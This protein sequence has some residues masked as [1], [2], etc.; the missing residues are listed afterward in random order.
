MLNRLKRFLALTLSMVMFISMMPMDVLAETV[1]ATWDLSSTAA[2][3][4]SDYTLTEDNATVTASGT[5]FLEVGSSVT[6]TFQYQNGS[7]DASYSSS[8]SD[9]ASVGST[10]RTG[11]KT[12]TYTTTL[13]AKAVGTATIS[14]KYYN[15]YTTLTVYVVAASPRIVISGDSKLDISQSGAS[16]TLSLA[17]ANL[18]ENVAIS[19]V[20]W[21]VSGNATLS[22]KSTTGVVVTPTSAAAVGNT[23]TVT[24]VATLNDADATELT[25][26][27][28]ITYTSIET[29]IV[30]SSTQYAW[31]NEAKT[32]TGTSN[33][34]NNHWTVSNNS[35]MKLDSWTG[36]TTTSTYYSTG[37][38]YDVSLQVSELG[39]YT[40]GHS[41]ST[42]Q[43]GTDNNTKSQNIVVVVYGVKLNSLSDMYV[44]EEQTVTYTSKLP[45][46][47]TLS[48]SEADKSGSDVV[49][50]DATT[51]VIT[52]KN[53]GTATITL[54]VTESSGTKHTYTTE[55]EVIAA[56]NVAVSKDAVTLAVGDSTELTVTGATAS[57]TFY[58]SDETIASCSYSDGKLTITGVKDGDAVVYGVTTSGDTVLVDV[59]VETVGINVEPGNL[60]T[61]GGNIYYVYPEIVVPAGATYT[62]AVS[63]DVTDGDLITGGNYNT[64]DGSLA[65]NTSEVSANTDVVVTFTMAV[66]VNGVTTNYTDTISVKL[67]PK[68]ESATT[69][70]N[71][72]F[73]DY[74]GN[75]LSTQTVASADAIVIPGQPNSIDGYTYAGF[76][77]VSTADT[78]SY[79]TGDTIDDADLTANTILFAQYNLNQYNV[80]FTTAYGTAPETQTVSHGGLVTEP[81]DLGTSG[82]YEFSHWYL[83]TDS[84][85]TAY[86]FYTPVTGDI[87]L[88][89]K[90]EPKTVTVTLITYLG[91]YE[92]YTYNYVDNKW[93]DSSN[94]VVSS[95]TLPKFTSSDTDGNGNS[96]YQYTITNT[97]SG[98]T[99]P[100]TFQFW[101]LADDT[102]YVKK[103]GNTS[104][105]LTSIVSAGEDVTYNAIYE[106][107]SQS[108]TESN[109]SHANTV[110]VTVQLVDEDGNVQ[111]TTVLTDIQVTPAYN[112]TTLMSG[113]T[114][115]GV[116]SSTAK[117]GTISVS[118]L[119][120]KTVTINNKTYTVTDTSDVSVSDLNVV[121]LCSQA[122]HVYGGTCRGG[123]W[124]ALGVITL[125]VRENLSSDSAP[126]LRVNYYQVP[127]TDYNPSDAVL[128][129]TK[130]PTIAAGNVLVHSLYENGVV[131]STLTCIDHE[132]ENGV[133]DGTLAQNGNY[134][135]LNLYY[136][137]QPYT[138]TYHYLIEGTT[139]ELY[140]SVTV[141]NLLNGYS[142]SQVSPSHDRAD[143]T[144]IDETDYTL[145]NPSQ[146]VVNVTIDGANAVVYVYYKLNVGNLTITKIV[147]NPDFT[148][149]SFTFTVDDGDPSTTD[150]TATIS[151][152]TK[153]DDG[154]FTGTATVTD[155]QVG[156]YTVKETAVSGYT[157]DKTDASVTIA[158]GQTA[159]VTFTNTR[160]ATLIIKKAKGANVT[161]DATFGFTVATEDGKLINPTAG[162]ANIGFDGSET[163]TVKGDS[164]Y[165][166]TEAITDGYYLT[167]VA[168]T[169]NG[170]E[171]ENVS[172]NNT[173]T[174]T[175]PAGAVVEITYT[176]DEQLGEFTVNK[177]GSGALPLDGVAFTLY[178]AEENDS[179]ATAIA[180]NDVFT[181]VTTAQDNTE[182]EAN[183]DGT[184]VF[185]NLPIGTYYVVETQ[186]AAG[187]QEPNAETHSAKI[188]VIGNN[189]NTGV[190]TVKINGSEINATT[191]TNALINT[192]SF[193]LKK[194]VVDGLYDKTTGKFNFT[195]ELKNTNADRLNYAVKVN[196]VDQTA[197]TDGTYN[198][199]AS[200]ANGEYVTIEGMP[201]DTVITVTETGADADAWDIAWSNDDE[202]TGYEATDVVITAN[203]P[204]QTL[205]ATNTRVTKKLTATKTWS[206]QD[207]HFELR[208]TTIE[209]KLYRYTTSVADAEVVDTVNMTVESGNS[210]TIKVWENL[211]AYNAAGTAYNYYIVEAAIAN[212][213]ASNNDTANT[214]S[215]TDGDESI[216]ITNTLNVNQMTVTKTWVETA[217]M[218]NGVAADIVSAR[219]GMTF[220]L[221]NTDW[222]Q[223]NE[224]VDMAGD[225][226]DYSVVF[227][228]S[229]PVSKAYVLVESMN[230][231]GGY[232]YDN[233]AITPVTDANG[234][235]TGFTVV[236]TLK[237]MDVTVTKKW[238]DNGITGL[239]HPDATF[240][241]YYTNTEGKDIV[242]KTISTPTESDEMDNDV[243]T[244]LFDGVPLRTDYKVRET[245][246]AEETIYFTVD[247]TG[248]AVVDGAATITNES[249][250]GALVIE[251]AID[252]CGTD[253][254]TTLDN[255]IF[256]FEYSTDGGETWEPAGSI[257]VDLDGGETNNTTDE[258]LFPV[259]TEVMVREVL[260]EEQQIEWELDTTASNEE[261]T[262]VID[263]TETDAAAYFENDRETIEYLNVIKTWNDKNGDPNRRPESVTFGLYYSD[264][265]TPVKKDGENWTVTL[266][267][268]PSETQQTVSF[269]NVPYNANGYVVIETMPES[270]GAYVAVDAS[271]ELSYSETTAEFTN[272]PTEAVVTVKKQIVD[273]T[274]DFVNGMESEFD[275]TVTT[276]ADENYNV[277]G[278]DI[279][280]EDSFEFEVKIGTEYTLTENIDAD[281]WTASYENATK[282]TDNTA[283][284][285]ADEAAE[286]IVVTNTRNSVALELDK[287][288]IDDNNAQGTRP[289]TIDVIVEVL[290][291]NT[292]TTVTYDGENVCETGISAADL[293]G[294]DFTDYNGMTLPKTDLDGVAN[295]Y[296]LNEVLNTDGVIEG[297]NEATYTS[298]VTGVV[299]TVTAITNQLGNGSTSISFT[300]NWVD[301]SNELSVRPSTTDYAGWLHLYQSTDEENWTEVSYTA[302]VTGSGNAYS[303][304]YS[305]LP[306][307]DNAGKLYYYAVAETIPTGSEYTQSG[308]TIEVADGTLAVGNDDTLTNKLVGSTELTITKLW[309]D[310]DGN[311]LETIPE[312]TLNTALTRYVTVNGE[313]TTATAFADGYIPLTADNKWT[314][315]I[316]VDKYDADG[317]LYT[318]GVVEYNNAADYNADKQTAGLDNSIEEGSIVE[319][320]DDKKYAVDY[321]AQDN[322]QIIKN[323]RQSE[324]D[325]IPGTKTATEI[326]LNTYVDGEK[327]DV[328]DS[329]TY[330]ITWN[331]TT[332]K[333]Q[334][335]TI[336]DE[337]KP[338]L[339][340][341]AHTASSDDTVTAVTGA[342][343][344]LDGEH[345]ETTNTVTWQF[346]AKPFHS[347]SVTVT[348]QL[349]DKI[350]ALY[351]ADKNLV[352]ENE[353]TVEI[354]SD[355]EL[356]STPVAEDIPVSHPAIDVEKEITTTNE[357]GSVKTAGYEL[358]ETV[359]YKVTVTNTGNL[360]LTD[361]KVVDIRDDATVLDTTIKTMAL[362][363]VEYFTYTHTVTEEDL[364]RGTIYNT[365]TV[366]A[367][368]PTT[369][370]G[371]LT[372]SDNE[373]VTT[374]AVEPQLT[375]VKDVIT[376][377]EN[378]S[379]K[380]GGY[381]LGETVSYKVTLT[382][383]GNVT[384][385]NVIFTDDRVLDYTKVTVDGAT[386][387]NVTENDKITS[388]NVGDMAPGKVITFTYDYVIVEADLWNVEVKNVA[389]ATGIYD[390]PDPD[391]TVTA[392]D[393]E[394]VTTVG[395]KAAIDVTKAV[396]DEQDYYTED[397]TVDFTITVTN[398]G[399]VTLSNV[400]L[401]DVMNNSQPVVIESTADYTVD[402]AKNGTVTVAMA[403][404]MLPGASITL[405]A[406][407]EVL[408]YDLQLDTITN[409]VTAVGKTEKGNEVKDDAEADFRTDKLITYTVNKV[410][411]NTVNDVQ[412]TSVT[413]ELK[414]NGATYKTATLDK[415]NG[416]KYTFT[417]LP[418]TDTDHE[419][420]DYIAV[421]TKIGNS[422]VENNAANGYNVT[423]SEETGVNAESESIT[424]TNTQQTTSVVV[425]KYW[426]DGEWTEGADP[427]DHLLAFATDVP[428]ALDMDL[429]NDQTVESGKKDE[430]AATIDKSIN[431]NGTIW[432]YT[433]TKLP[434]YDA[435]GDKITYSA[436]EGTVEGF[437]AK[438]ETT[439]TVVDGKAT[440]I[441]A[442][443]DEKPEKPVKDLVEDQTDLINVTLGD[444]NMA[445]DGGTITYTIAWSNNYATTRE[446][447][448]IDTL[449]TGLEYI[450][451]KNTVNTET[452]EN[453]QTITWIFEAK[454]FEDGVITV[455]VDVDRA[456]IIAAATAE[457]KY[458]PTVTNT[459][460]MIVSDDDVKRDS[461]PVETSVYNPI[462][463][464]VKEVTDESHN[465]NG[466][467]LGEEISYK[468]TITNDGNVPLLNVNVEDT[469]VA[470]SNMEFTST[471]DEATFVNGVISR[472]EIGDVVTLTY[473]YTVTEADVKAEAHTVVNEVTATGTAE[474]AEQ[475]DVTDNDSTTSKT[476]AATGSWIPE[477]GE[478]GAVGKTIVG[479]DLVA[480]EFKFAITDETHNKTI[481]GTN[482]ANG[483]VTFDGEFTYTLTDLV[484]FEDL[485]AADD[486]TNAVYTNTFT[487][488]VKEITGE[489]DTVDYSNDVYTY[490]V[491]Y[492][493]NG[494]GAIV[495]VIDS[496]TM[497]DGKTE[498][499][500]IKVEFDNYAHINA[501]VTKAWENV[502]LVDVPAVEITLYRKA[503]AEMPETV[504]GTWDPIGT[505]TIASGETSVTWEN[506]ERVD[507]YGVEYTYIATETVKGDFAG[508]Y[509]ASAVVVE[510]GDPDA[511]NV[512]T[513][514]FTNSRDLGAANG[515][516]V[517][518]TIV[519][520][521]KAL[522]DEMKVDKFDFVVTVPG[523]MTVGDEITYT[524]GTETY[525]AEI[526]KNDTYGT[527]FVIE[528]IVH[529]Q[530]ATVTNKLPI[531]TYNVVELQDVENAY[532][533]AADWGEAKNQQI[534]EKDKTVAFT[535]TNTVLADGFTI[536][537]LWKQPNGNSAISTAYDLNG[538]EHTATFGLFYDADGENAVQQNGKALVSTTT[539]DGVVVFE[540]V[541]L[542][543][544]SGNNATYYIKEISTTTD[545]YVLNTAAIPVV[546]NGTK[547]VID[548]EKQVVV[549]E[550]QTYDLTIQK[551]IDWNGTDVM[552]IDFTI[553]YSYDE[554]GAVSEALP[555][556]EGETT[557][558]VIGE[559]GASYSAET[560]EITHT[561]DVITVPYGTKV[562]VTETLPEADE[563]GNYVW[564]NEFD[565]LDDGESFITVNDNDDH[566]IVTVTNT[567]AY[568]PELTVEKTYASQ[569]KVLEEG[570]SYELGDTVEYTIKVENT[571]NVT[572]TNVKIT[573]D[574]FDLTGDNVHF[575]A[576][577]EEATFDKE[578]STVSVMKPGDE[579][580]FLY[581]VVITEDIILEEGNVVTNTV[582]VSAD[583]PKDPENPIE[584]EDE[585][586]IPVEEP[587][588]SIDV[589]K[590]GEEHEGAYELGETI[591][592]TIVV[593]NTGNLTISDIVV[594]DELTGDQWTIESLAPEAS[595]TF[596]ASYTVTEADLFAD[597]VINVATATG[598][599]PTD[600]D[601]TDE[602][603]EKDPTDEPNDQY[604][605]V[606]TLTN[607]PERGYFVLGEKA[608]FEIT[609]TNTGN[610]TLYNVIVNEELEGAT[611]VAESIE[612]VTYSEDG[613][614]ATIDQLDPVAFETAG[615]VVVL[616][617]VYTIT[618]DDLGKT[619]DLGGENAVHN[620]NNTLTSES[621]HEDPN[622]PD[623]VP[624][625]PDPIDPVPVPVDDVTTVSV[626]K[627]WNDVENQFGT[628]QTITVN[629]LAD[630][631]IYKTAAIS[632][633]ENGAW[634][635][636]FDKLPVHNADTS[637]IEYTVVEETVAGYDTT[638][639]SVATEDG[640][641]WTITNTLQQY[642]LTVR[643]WY[644]QIGGEVA[645]DTFTRTYYYGESYNVTSPKING[646]SVDIEVVSGVIT[647]NAE[648]DVIYT[649]IDYRLTVYY[650]YEDGTTAA[651]THRN[652]LH[653][654]DGYRVVSPELEGYVA[655]RRLV[656]GTMPGH[657]LVYTVIYVP[658]TV[659]IDEYGVPL[660]IGSIVMNVGDCF[661]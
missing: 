389:T 217:T 631:E 278:T 144:D 291:G 599:A 218:D 171:Q 310:G 335:I 378:G 322:V 270:D 455:T 563:D 353:A 107:S 549:N 457:G 134:Y 640:A 30:T 375:L 462:I 436:T 483:N 115:T 295:E 401:T 302:T 112:N 508:S 450:G 585:E 304:T 615:E 32:I 539:D 494:E 74:Y 404:P 443:D 132:W 333:A 257:T 222:A 441:N 288:W 608:E 213:T 95:I 118:D 502:E 548:V 39:M 358:G 477:T 564:T 138:A 355:P 644:E 282:A 572:L 59:T 471:N 224:T 195:I 386:A 279:G 226:A 425:T 157:A 37:T 400:T 642:T 121:W 174:I 435:E 556:D 308:A 210:Q 501:T 448:I 227:T 89:A 480:G 524:V 172:V 10:N 560:G 75:L 581:E 405:S 511:D 486:E 7:D 241:L 280:H 649:P 393:N 408:L 573:D 103:D 284:F 23:V 54:T 495:A 489:D 492:T 275:F 96:Y 356:K 476:Y 268:D 482:D 130:T 621:T 146:A 163:F 293:D 377:N 326:T 568:N 119:L 64:T 179:L 332:N 484:E 136:Y 106:P 567:R 598:K 472:M 122:A 139:T 442:K 391:E 440:F 452:E 611:F 636:T 379:T 376:K 43:N 63:D 428:S 159:S 305:N 116:N 602:D 512:K 318:Y 158:G 530:T 381:V 566:N 152:F 421:E 240:E 166:I 256:A 340:Y 534:L 382:N 205:T 253:W 188:E 533:Y 183:E 449:P 547:F 364:E 311:T 201:L 11:K 94:N 558:D 13:T 161:H 359:S 475:D 248:V 575:D 527:Y 500:V 199:N 510:L 207:N 343:A 289:E 120:G 633:D 281:D 62:I 361:V 363:A 626:T 461:N 88:V 19:S 25:T 114:T 580:Y 371:N 73:Y 211:P 31:I 196:G 76:D 109:G 652:T 372:D 336:T 588:P 128:L 526:Q 390:T 528:D 635:C 90:W 277:A 233:T 263:A 24:A 77:V 51:G 81:A 519:N 287:T 623:P 654:N 349:N 587:A 285:T 189:S 350:D 135:V 266:T 191:I 320:S 331:N 246:L 140:P 347:G 185:S 416:W 110:N 3:Y 184:A 123:T 60:T 145:V 55:V 612:G 403:E 544:K 79:T 327:V 406:S 262:H 577:N 628:R 167:G 154:T 15:T 467:Q 411:K 271:D 367:D 99:K 529:G 540:N 242:V 229:M 105:D 653:I 21:T 61:V 352:A 265:E 383:S 632:A 535:A 427:A 447:T 542:T 660:N 142:H 36:S 232:H 208:P 607:L 496:I 521:E 151:D 647:G 292:W 92:T 430:T 162:N 261:L 345:D 487:Y 20:E 309:L 478:N 170:T 423:Y 204:A 366:T 267:T 346:I 5:I 341:D 552:D 339:T 180:K 518:K 594:T 491:T 273:N 342:E 584:D 12:K 659:I 338:Y 177:T 592:Y 168:I 314:T 223:L 131:S 357:D 98:K 57:V 506:L 87:N 178:K 597:E 17:S 546:S 296:R 175:I 354:G 532:D 413:V 650:V 603:D 523:D 432:T 493:D 72:T 209:Y 609:V 373:T 9:C 570:D 290:N 392:T 78:E 1:S 108:G 460:Q 71:V 251:K 362:G 541:A 247:S 619:E 470:A 234:N 337:L 344:L 655:S 300:K 237:T 235:V 274:L 507:E 458:D 445:V 559:V 52:A 117:F 148:T 422:E 33:T 641:A 133:V 334:V 426:V 437:T 639:E 312:T 303:V 514:G 83:S 473:T 324:D 414:R 297:Q 66:T 143:T 129:A 84:T 254:D 198:I 498:D 319:F 412:P 258:I 49:D 104:L 446:I 348:V 538:D 276:D 6:L 56:A 238:D 53:A 46:G 576:I 591:N 101:V 16:A 374:E 192:T 351:K 164:T 249:N 97:T 583:D 617:A 299:G 444:E 245:A 160:N 638:Y 439:L 298:T 634:T 4:A 402:T 605:V 215:L 203:E 431:A 124:N 419:N 451:S 409:K 586:D 41:W 565:G 557:A 126:K 80:T 497:N 321:V 474:S 394:T 85:Q 613:T 610:L 301:N 329:W 562:T 102:Q 488:T 656:S 522:T 424:I 86:N 111:G 551:V 325:P 221:T 648:Y 384:L 173:Q 150:K 657:D 18:S 651:P 399:N 596:E 545:N 239:E 465:E 197:T 323:T 380:M 579:I 255:P 433:F 536:N 582:T 125:T 286:E 516:S 190:A 517:T 606:K 26:N 113:Y 550:L 216:N 368:D 28:T 645:A 420:F 45:T 306:R 543:D 93:Y 243:D 194:T 58:S 464:V 48:W 574:R 69:Y 68:D 618:E 330:T 187:Y 395:V 589:V 604:T 294:Y 231:G 561:G 182:T 590:T 661:E 65:L 622:D 147:K 27:Y 466:Y 67:T 360:T 627:V 429:T 537:K 181:I 525:T 230:G 630:G 236:N 44:G 228:R 313:K 8:N 620:L 417:D 365:V 629:L 454:P 252:M 499:T 469:I 272:Y 438:T 625:E 410:W 193:T 600:E 316:T 315:K 614:S 397:E 155:L 38:D 153:N 658:A 388:L 481:T 47:A 250:Y 369:D 206:D 387:E 601:V 169:I 396:V 127:S 165:T 264:G 317:A 14:L 571:G 244:Y 555:V 463:T 515:L 643:Y 453:G 283:T 225:D 34:Y 468:V 624:T 370:E 156:S 407:Y 616:H 398:T 200:L 385:H 35:Y 22:N 29:E 637:V 646:Y 50:I 509:T 91:V 82:N 137:A 307:F 219:P 260:T 553:D 569:D 42:D 456:A 513:A 459:A 141:E 479:R 504:D 415:D 186:Q 434:I 554:A 212:Y 503:G 149:G 202:N 490:T 485:T 418:L 70:Y 2:T 593:T 40:V 269:T 259:G 328:G 520:G 505:K 214:V 220:T 100:A 531:G 176:N 595:E 578:T